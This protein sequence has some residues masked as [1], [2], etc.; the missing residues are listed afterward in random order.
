MSPTPYTRG[1]A[2]LLL[3]RGSKG[4]ESGCC[5]LKAHIWCIAGWYYS[6]GVGGAN[7]DPILCAAGIRGCTGRYHCRQCRAAASPSDPR[8]PLLAGGSSPLSPPPLPLLP[9]PSPVQP[10]PSPLPPPLSTFLL[11]PPHPPLF[12]TLF[13]A[14]S[15]EGHSAPSSRNASAFSSDELRTFCLY[16]TCTNTLWVPGFEFCD[17]DPRP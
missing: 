7:G 2:P 4:I 3:L 6:G 9:S 14:Q 13:L 12:V 8:K 11:R 16:F 15:G 1:C 17:L 10:P 5:A